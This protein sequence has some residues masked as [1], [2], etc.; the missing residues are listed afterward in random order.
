MT[1]N[2]VSLPP[3]QK[4]CCL[5]AEIV[6]YIIE[7]VAED[8]RGEGEK[9]AGANS[10]L[11]RR[12]SLQW[13]RCTH[14]CRQWRSA[15]IQHAA[16]WNSIPAVPR[17]LWTLYADRARRLPLIIREL[18]N[19]ADQWN[20]DEL[21]RRLSRART[22][23]YRGS[24]AALRRMVAILANCFEPILQDLSLEIDG[25]TISNLV[26]PSEILRSAAST[27]EHLRLRNIAFIWPDIPTS[28]RTLELSG[29]LD[30]PVED[31]MGGLR[32]TQ[33]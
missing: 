11:A 21:T 19:D 23:A 13:L 33:N 15:A 1:D 16:L 5:P 26:L 9:L 10:L 32:A 29:P 18:P 17:P 28:L 30:D 24:P 3:T 14:T 4:E 22:F 20:R 8:A 12:A 7:L 6:S 27:F 2:S 25:L 31:I